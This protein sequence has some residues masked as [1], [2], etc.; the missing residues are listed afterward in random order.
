M[1]R[2]TQMQDII[3]VYRKNGNPWLDYNEIYTQMNKSLF[4]PNKYGEAG[5]KRIVYRYLLGN[6]MFDED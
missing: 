1:A 4:G 3:R 2:T 5:Q 6:E